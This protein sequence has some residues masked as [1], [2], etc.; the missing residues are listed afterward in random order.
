MKIMRLVRC[1]LFFC[2]LVLPLFAAHAQSSSQAPEDYTFRGFYVGANAGGA[3]TNGDTRFF[4]LPDAATFFALK[5]TTVAPQ[6]NGWLAGGGGGYNFQYK[7]F[8]F[9]VEADIQGA[10]IDG[11]RIVTPIIQNDGTSAGVGTQLVVH[12]E[13]NW[14]GTVRPRFGVTVGRRWLLYGTGGLAYGHVQWM[15]QTDYTAVGGPGYMALQEETKVGWTAGGGVE[16]LLTPHWSLR[17]EYLYYDLGSTHLIANPV[18]P[19]PPFQV[20]YAFNNS[21]NIMR[22]GISFRF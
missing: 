12:H 13:M 16:V 19:N 3:W 1:G 17:G 9:G 18:P 14:I 21:G 7:R 6:P 10:G 20:G 5:P 11:T 8:V 22:G 15:G 2:L 4:P